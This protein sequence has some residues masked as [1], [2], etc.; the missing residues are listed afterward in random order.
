LKLQIS[1]LSVHYGSGRNRLTAVDG[2]DLVVPKNGTLGLVGESGSGKS[3]VAKAIVGLIPTTRGRFILD[4]VDYSDLRK[5]NTR[6]FRRRVQMVFQDPYSSLN[7]RMTIGEM[8]GEGLAIRGV[9]RGARFNQ[10]TRLL[11]MVGLPARVIDR[12]PHQFSGGQRQRLAIARALAVGPE[13]IVTDEVTSSLDVS[14]QATILNLLRELQRSLSLSFL[15]ISHDLSTVRY[16]SDTVSVM[17]L[18][19]V[20]E[21]AR[22][23]DLFFS[24]EHPYSKAL[25]ASVPQ[26]GAAR[27][28]A[29]LSGDLPDPT[30]PPPGCRFHTRCP[31]GPNEF[32]ERTICLTTD[33]QTDAPHRKHL[34]ACH[35]ALAE[36]DREMRPS[37]LIGSPQPIPL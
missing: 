13:L 21:T 28:R 32:P 6:E 15:F 10:T 5:R 27:R 14:V 25:I 2:A 20:V 12:Y 4:N 18:G 33:P 11:D 16:M 30:R 8:L 34:A 1:G 7:P 26:V 29:P 24:P 22:T 17:Y 9:S 31:V 35:Y 3:T 23:E 37:R 36:T 19:R